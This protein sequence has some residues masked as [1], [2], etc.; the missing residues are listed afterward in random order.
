MANRKLLVKLVWGFISLTFSL[1]VGITSIVG[2]T[3]NIGR[4][5]SKPLATWLIV[6]GSCILLS[7]LFVLVI[8]A[9]PEDSDD[10]LCIS[11]ISKNARNWVLAVVT[12]FVLSLVVYGM[13]VVNIT[14]NRTCDPSLHRFAFLL[15]VTVF[16]ISFVLYF[17][18]IYR[19]LCFFSLFTESCTY[20]IYSFLDDWLHKA[21]SFYRQIHSFT[22]M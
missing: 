12:L 7:Q 13:V 22:H 15:T 14:N 11:S 8:M 17:L 21:K 9:W 19:P 18:W 16:P 10:F 1:I 6:Y 20:V 4:P 2:G 5:C 3:K